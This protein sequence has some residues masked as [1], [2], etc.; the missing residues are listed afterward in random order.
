MFR[1]YACV[2]QDDPSGCGPAAL[3]TVALHYRIPVSAERLRELA[4][5]DRA[6]TNLG[7]LLAAA[8]RLGFAARAVK[9][10]YPALVL[11]PLPAVAHVRTD[12]G[13]GHFLVVHRA[14][15]R[16]VVVADPADGVLRLSWD[17]FSR[18]WT[19]HLLLLAPEENAGAGVPG[20]P[21]PPW[22][23]FLGLLRGHTPLL[24][25][26]FG[27]ALLMLL[28]GVA[29][30]YF[31]QHLVDYV[32]VRRERQLLNALAVGMLAV[33][34]FRAAFGLLRQYLLAHVGRRADLALMAGYARHI[35]RLPLAFFEARQPGDILARAIDAGKVREA[36]SGTTTNALVDSTLVAL[37]LGILAAYDLPLA[38]VAGAFVPLLVVAVAAHHPATA[39][40]SRALMEEGA[41]FSA[42]LV[43]S[44]SAA[45]TVKAFGAE[46]SRA[47]QGEERVVGVVQ[48]LYGLELLGVSMGSAGLLVSAAAAVAV[49]W[50]GGH[51]VMSGALSVG[52]LFFFAAL[53][54]YLLEPLERL[55]GVNL[56][57][58]EALVA[59]D[60]L[61]QVLD[62]PAEPLGDPGKVPLAAV[63]D[64]I[65]LDGVTFAYGCRGNVLEGV[66][67]RIPAGATVALV[68]ESGSGKSTLL[69]LLL[70]FYAPTGGRILFDG[71]DTRDIEPGSLRGRIGVVSQEPFVFNGTLRENV[72]LGRPGATP[73]DV[74]DAVRAAGLEEFVSRL[75]DRYDTVLGE[76]GANLSGGQRQRLAIA[77]ALLRRPDVLIFDEATSHLDAATERLIQANLR[78]ASAGRTV[79]LV[80]HRLSTVR[81]AD[82]IFVLHQG[83]LVEQGTH[84]QLLARGGRYA[85]LC[86]AQTD[87]DDGPPANGRAAQ[88]E[89]SHA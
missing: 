57:L 60:R 21:A 81:H 42:H 78:A 2:R 24:A 27:C 69:K 7:G 64:G 34:A 30:S 25:E 39:R 28:L 67:L 13:L 58:Q 15:R 37:L 11:L 48:S 79:L 35:L 68:G 77:R 61:Y 54:G 55:A 47:E 29:G 84:R 87:A 45:E 73:S 52:Q 31:V 44:V 43:E 80:A 71:I 6:G 88:G 75:P 8:E 1:R 3:A 16:G 40:R 22:R 49:L 51:R 62:L 53:L 65:E 41:C 50:V 38:L 12:T 89:M 86:R 46:R 66:S 18:R 20:R 70:G 9:S 63:R 74:I 32:L 10:S 56:R 82:L 83:R 26:A 14:G 23:R 5:T 76:R 59:V 33:A 4:G 19:G 17:E 72:A 85:E 36:I